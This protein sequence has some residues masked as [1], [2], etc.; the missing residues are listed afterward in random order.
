[1][2]TAILTHFTLQLPYHDAV[3]ADPT[4]LQMY[5]VVVIG[6][7]FDSP[8]DSL[9]L[10]L[11]LPIKTCHLCSHL[12][13]RTQSNLPGEQHYQLGFH[14]KRPSLAIGGHSD[15]EESWLSRWAD[16]IAECWHPCYTHRLSALRVRKTLAAI[17]A[18]LEQANDH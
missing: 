8:D 16:V 18:M 14:G 17:E 7:T 5:R 1:M 15:A 11:P 3:P 12:L 9:V 6:E 13:F 4:F 10:D 2:I